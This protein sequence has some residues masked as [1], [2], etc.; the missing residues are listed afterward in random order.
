MLNLVGHERDWNCLYGFGHSKCSQKFCR[1]TPQTE[2]CFGDWN[3]HRTVMCVFDFSK[4]LEWLY[5]NNLFQ[6][7]RLHTTQKINTK[8]AVIMYSILTILVS[9]SG[10]RN[11]DETLSK[12]SQSFTW[13]SNPV[14][15]NTNVRLFSHY[16]TTCHQRSNPY[17]SIRR[18]RLTLRKGMV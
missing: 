5:L 11:D 15:S 12:N 14:I 13:N 1:E 10:N 4:D 17:F 2:N 6:L 3:T 16:M 7:Y 8:E 18:F 9:P